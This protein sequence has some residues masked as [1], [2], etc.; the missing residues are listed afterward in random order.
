MYQHYQAIANASDPVR[1]LAETSQSMISYWPAAKNLPYGRWVEAYLEQVSLMGLT[2]QR[3]PFL[4]D[5]IENADGSRT[6]IE[7][8][9]M[10]R[11]V[12]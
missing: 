1:K 4:I 5:A 7:E 3:P 11:R 10:S 2:H 9:I 12:F 8:T 6:H